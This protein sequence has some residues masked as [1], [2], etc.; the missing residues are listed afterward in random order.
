MNAPAPEDRD[1][2]R[3]EVY[4]LADALLCDG[5]SAEEVQ[6]LERLLCEDAE[7]RRHYVRFMHHSA[8]LCRLSSAV[9]DAEGAEGS[10]LGRRTDG[11]SVPRVSHAGIPPSSFLLHP[12]LLTGA[13]LC[14]AV[15]VL[16]VGVG[17]FAAWKWK[18]PFDS[19]QTSTNVAVAPLGR[20]DPS[21]TSVVGKVTQSLNCLW[22]DSRTATKAGDPVTLGR[23]Y[24]LASGLLEITYDT[25]ATVVLEGR[26][27]YQA[28]T[29]E[30]G[31]LWLGK[32]TTK[33]ARRSGKSSPPAAVFSLCVPQ[34]QGVACTVAGEGA[35][36]VQFVDASG[37]GMGKVV[38][39]P[40]WLALPDWKNLREVRE[41]GGGG[42]VRE[43][44]TADHRLRVHIEPPPPP[45]VVAPNYPQGM[46]TYG[47]TKAEKNGADGNKNTHDINK[48]G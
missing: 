27:M 34:K 20:G 7:A 40:V 36:F 16:I 26:V 38:K 14:Y 28:D 13:P 46:P 6:R 3:R 25:G 31:M 18:T 32:A 24:N 41:K 10:R 1:L 43:G 9:M 8:R 12:A 48:K 30:S 42:T 17:L 29:A 37:S 5:L 45:E 35:E 47:K 22:A 23:K 39:A 44:V 19:P 11:K 33:V 21:E 4:E 15:A 2:T